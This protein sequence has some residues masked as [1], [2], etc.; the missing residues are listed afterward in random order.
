MTKHLVVLLAYVVALEASRYGDYSGVRMPHY[1]IEYE[2]KEPAPLSDEYSDRSPDAAASFDYKYEEEPQDKI[3]TTD[4]DQLWQKMSKKRK[5]PLKEPRDKIEIDDSDLDTVPKFKPN[6]RFSKHRTRIKDLHKENDRRIFKYHRNRNDEIEDSDIK[7]EHKIDKYRSKTDNRID[8]TNFNFR[9]TTRRIV[10]RKPRD[11]T[12]NREILERDEP[13]DFLRSM[14]NEEDPSDNDYD[15]MKRLQTTM[16]RPRGPFPGLM[17]NNKNNLQEYDEYYDMKRV[18]IIKNKLPGIFRQT[19]ASTTI[20][21]PPSTRQFQDLSYRRANIPEKVE[22][23]VVTE[24]IPTDS[25]ARRKLVEITSQAI[26]S[27]ESPISMS[28]TVLSLAEKSR[29]S[30][31][32]KAQ[33]KDNL[34]NVTRTTKPPVLMLVTQQMNTMVMVEHPKKDVLFRARAVF[35]DSPERIARAKTLMR[36]KLVSGARRIEDLIDNW[37]EMVCD[38]ID[39]SLLNNGDVHHLSPDLKIIL[40]S[41]IICSISKDLV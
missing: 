4:E 3:G 11:R 37:D 13:P 20:T 32:K 24:A 6:H 10:R 30:I 27:P 5:R 12:I 26:A 9:Q 34:G 2:N 40:L 22:S 7:N 39:V 16:E 15:K 36:R 35:D 41:V 28:S 25:I 19:K 1:N 38:Y 18:N 8:L 23:A 33:R 29:L 21:E 17:K 14:E 31:L